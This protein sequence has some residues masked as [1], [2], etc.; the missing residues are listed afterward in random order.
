[1]AVGRPLVCGLL[2][3][4]AAADLVS[5]ART[6]FGRTRN[7]VARAIRK[8]YWE[9][10]LAAPPATQA[11]PVNSSAVTPTGQPPTR[12]QDSQ[13]CAF[14]ELPDDI[15]LAPQLS[16]RMVKH[17][18][19]QTLDGAQQVSWT[20]D[21]FSWDYDT[22][23]L[24]AMD[25]VLARM[26]VITDLEAELPGYN[27]KLDS[28]KEG[29]FTVIA[30]K[31]CADQLLYVFHEHKD[32][33]HNYRIFNRD[34]ELVAQMIGGALLYDQMHIY[35]DKMVPFALAQSPTIVEDSF[36]EHVRNRPDAVFGGVPTYQLRFVPGYNSNS[37]LLLP[38]NRWVLAAALQERAC[39]NAMRFD[40]GYPPAYPWFVGLLG[41]FGLVLVG[42]LLF[43]I[44]MIFRCVY[45]KFYPEIENS[46]LQS[47][48]QKGQFAE[49]YGSAEA[50]LVSSPQK[51]V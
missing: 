16:D 15:M 2:G 25:K 19:W 51:S 3:L 49:F 40:G 8:P 38:Q 32:V 42:G 21:L 5:C 13:L 17:G 48:V 9:P 6:G 1:M 45:P 36:N 39:R 29:P 47:T 33:K 27:I 43:L 14:V 34:E 7:E 41:F 22:I 20:Q 4:L 23:Y 12:G 30:V 50:S 18:T 44:H 26:D 10:K 46:F 37:S 35:D 28:K 31:D 11:P 24:K